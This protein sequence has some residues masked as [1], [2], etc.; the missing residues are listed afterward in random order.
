MPDKTVQSACTTRPLAAD[1][2]GDFAGLVAA[3]NGVWG[4]CWCM[5]FHPEGVG[6]DRAVARNRE[7]KHAH[8]RRG[9]VRQVL[10]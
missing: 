7:A 2:W 8:V 9:T 1:T 6:K 10:V 3:N 4:G 5:G